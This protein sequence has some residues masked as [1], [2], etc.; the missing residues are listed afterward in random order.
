M[1]NRVTAEQI[2]ASAW[3][4]VLT[5]QQSP[6][7]VPAGWFTAKQIAAKTGKAGSTI[8]SQLSH[9]VQQGRCERKSFRILTGGMVRPVPHYRLK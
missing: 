7:K 9:A 5:S 3:A 1:S 8:G 2:E 6:D 4:A